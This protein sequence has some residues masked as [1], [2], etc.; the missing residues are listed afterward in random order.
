MQDLRDKVAIITGAA[1]GQGAAT[2]EL[3]ASS[4]AKLVLADINEDLGSRQARKISD[5]G[6]AAVFVKVDVSRAADVRDMV[7]LA[8]DR[9]GK[10]DIAVNN[11]ARAQDTKP[12]AEMDE[13]DFDSVL[14]IDL[15]GVAL[16]LKYELAQMMAQGNGGTIIN[17]SSV[18]GIRPQPACPGYIAA[19][20]GVIGLT[21]SAARDYSPH[22]IRVN[23]IA[24]GAVDTPMLRTAMQR[25]GRDLAATGKLLSMLGRTAEAIEIA[26]ASLWLASPASS[27]VTGVVLPVDGGYTAM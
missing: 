18:S 12:L 15:K 8:V 2:A 13:A 19:K 5:G 24:P 23:T 10:L 17:I 21:K 9:Y 27:Y 4:G 16:C 26:Q 11:A 6:G 22:G 7:K 20:H 25:S 1:T 14:N 3:F